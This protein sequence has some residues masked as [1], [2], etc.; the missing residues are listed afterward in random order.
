[1]YVPI[2]SITLSRATPTAPSRGLFI[3]PLLAAAHTIVSPD[4]ND[5]QL[6]SFAFLRH[7]YWTRRPSLKLNADICGTWLTSRSR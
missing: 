2:S 4:V 5:G 1:M 7:D 3:L 6:H